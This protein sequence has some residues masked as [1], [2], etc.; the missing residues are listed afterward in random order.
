[1]A[2]APPFI[3]TAITFELTAAISFKRATW[4]SGSSYC[5][6]SFPSPSKPKSI[7]RKNRTASASAAVFTASSGVLL[8]RF[9]SRIVPAISH[10]KRCIICSVPFFFCT[11]PGVFFS[12][13]FYFSGALRLKQRFSRIFSN[14]RQLSA[15]LQRQNIL[16]IFQQNNGF[17]CCCADFFMIFF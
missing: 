2:T 15:L 10:R 8:L 4:Y 14:N 6:R 13:S 11:F 3:T 9:T 17:F 1:M 12:C 5:T 7:A 16:F